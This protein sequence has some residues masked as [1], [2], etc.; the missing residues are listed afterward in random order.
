MIVK[1]RGIPESKLVDVPLHKR[2]VFLNVI[3]SRR[4]SQCMEHVEGD[5]AAGFCNSALACY[6]LTRLVFR[7]HCF[8]DSRADQPF[9]PRLHRLSSP[10]MACSDSGVSRRHYCIR[11][12]LLSWL[13]QTSSMLGPDVE[14]ALTALKP[15]AAGPKKEWTRSQDADVPVTRWILVVGA[16][17]RIELG[18]MVLPEV[19]SAQWRLVRTS[20]EAWSD[21]RN[22]C[23]P[24]QK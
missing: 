7:Q 6:V 11:L 9:P 8:P 13:L 23:T 10:H 16:S 5:R 18:D 17:G 14:P 2:Q 20:L 4:G 24:C 12:L 22:F 3:H 15:A 1:P 19:R 21:D